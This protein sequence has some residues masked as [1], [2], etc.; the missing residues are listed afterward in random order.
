MII[1]TRRV[2]RQNERNGDFKIPKSV[3]GSVRSDNWFKSYRKMKDFAV[4]TMRDFLEAK[5]SANIVYTRICQQNEIAGYKV[6]RGKV[7]IEVDMDTYLQFE[8]AAKRVAETVNQAT[9]HGIYAL[10][11]DRSET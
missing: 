4:E 9:G 1:T 7:S 8:K 6:R 2:K 10:V 5:S 11:E 3:V